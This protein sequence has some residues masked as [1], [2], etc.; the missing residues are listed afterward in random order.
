[1]RVYLTEQEMAEFERRR[2][3]QQQV[4]S[5]QKKSWIII[6]IISKFVIFWPYWTNFVTE[7]L[8]Q[9][10]TFDHAWD[11]YCLFRFKFQT[12]ILH[13]HRHL[14]ARIDYGVGSSTPA[15]V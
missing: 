13:H 11:K 14:V 9:L 3:Q 4:Q 7:V 10:I 15:V 5:D 6:R 1:M 8:Y 12:K 2:Q